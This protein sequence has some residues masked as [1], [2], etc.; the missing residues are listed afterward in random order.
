MN[1][2]FKTKNLRLVRLLRIDRIIKNQI[3]LEWID[4][5]LFALI[6][7]GIFR[8][9][10]YAP[11]KVPTG[12][13]LQTI[14]RGDFLFANMH[15]YGFIIPFTDKK[16]FKSAIKRQDIVIF[17]YPQDPSV[18]FI[19]RVIG[20][21]GDQISI[22]NEIVFI[23]GRQ[24]DEPYKFLDTGFFAGRELEITVPQGKYFMMGDNR[25]NS[26]DSRFWGYVDEEKIRGQGKIVFWSHNPEKSLF[27]GYNLSRIG[28]L[29]K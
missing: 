5:I 8:T 25:R 27:K 16:I 7:V 1:L 19:K 22:R 2:K 10:G 14:Q 26:Q 29:L 6:V 13:M 3:I 28:H 23:N 21:P 17:P 4:A 9:W 15:S 11:Y 20:L 24:L 18:N 12:S